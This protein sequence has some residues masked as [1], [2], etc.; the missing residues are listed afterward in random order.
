M[1]YGSGGEHQDEPLYD[2]SLQPLTFDIVT[3]GTILWRQVGS[4]S[5][6]RR[7]ISYKINDG[8]SHDIYSTTGGAQINVHAGDKVL[9]WGSNNNTTYATSASAYN[10]FDGT[11]TYNVSG[12]IMSLLGYRLEG[13]ETYTFTSGKQYIFCCLFK[14]SKVISCE[15][16]ILPVTTLNIHCYSYMFQGCTNLNYIKVLGTRTT[17]N[18]CGNW[19]SGVSS[20]GTFY[21]KQGVSWASG[22]SGCPNGW[23]KIPVEV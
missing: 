11:A 5:S 13:D 18:Q 3:D 16:L 14:G 17:T 2:Y 7:A 9:I 23:T 22:V 20:T 21:H 4:S 1:V 12:N 19:V 10:C 8:D 15:N 6:V